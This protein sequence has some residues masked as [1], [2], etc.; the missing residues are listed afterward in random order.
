MN[1]FQIC[2]TAGQERYKSIAKIYYLKSQAIIFVYDITN[3]ESFNALKKLYNEVKDNLDINNVNVFIVGNK[4][5]L[6]LN[7]KVPKKDAEEYSKSINATYRCVSA[8][9][10][11][12]IKELF[13]CI[14]KT[15]LVGKEPSEEKKPEQNK[16]IQLKNNKK[17]EDPKGGKNKKKCC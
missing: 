5:D 13:E 7:E 6:Y 2:D 1:L 16:N 10:S 9:T 14:G 3:L 15:L 8:L 17:N 4:N 11:D 12:G